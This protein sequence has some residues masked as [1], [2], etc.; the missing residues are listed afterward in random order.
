M[1]GSGWANAYNAAQFRSAVAGATSGMQFW[2]AA[3][4]YK[5]AASNRD[6]SFY[7]PSGVKVYGGFAGT[8]TTLS[9]RNWNTNLTI[10]SGDIGVANDSSDNSYHV[11]LF[12]NADSTTL[13]DGFTITRGQAVDNDVNDT[14]RYGGGVLNLVNSSAH[15]RPAIKHCVFTHNTAS[16]GGGLADVSKYNST[17]KCTI[18]SCQFEFNNAVG[19]TNT[20]GGGAIATDSWGG[21]TWMTDLRIS[22]SIIRNNTSA[23]YGGGIY[24]YSNEARCMGDIHNCEISDNAAALGGGGICV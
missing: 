21:L 18:D 11:V 23:G 24:L 14:K 7:I 19:T 22:N 10:L 5:P 16:T 20:A 3:G 6:S 1:N 8:E 2:L 17:A 15:S 12:N 13:L 4:T 9:Q